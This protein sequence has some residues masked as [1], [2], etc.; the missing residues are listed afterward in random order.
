[1]YNIVLAMISV[2]NFGP[3]NGFGGKT[4]QEPQ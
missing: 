2:E 4:M 1:M 3:M